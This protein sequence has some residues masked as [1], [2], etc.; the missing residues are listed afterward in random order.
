MVGFLWRALRSA[1][2]CRARKLPGPLYPVKLLSEQVRLET[3]LTPQARRASRFTFAAKRVDEITRLAEAN[4]KGSGVMNGVYHAAVAA[5]LADFNDQ[6]TGAFAE[7][8]DLQENHNA[9]G[10]LA[11]ANEIKSATDGYQAALSRGED[12]GNDDTL[13]DI[14]Q[15]VAANND[16]NARAAA[17]LQNASGTAATSSAEATHDGGS[18]S[19]RDN[20]SARAENSG[21]VQN[22]SDGTAATNAKTS[23]LLRDGSAESDA[24]SGGQ[25]DRN[26]GNVQTDGHSGT[27]ANAVPSHTTI[28]PQVSSPVADPPA[29]S[30]LTATG[31]ATP[32]FIMT[33]STTS[34]MIGPPMPSSAGSSGSSLDGR[35]T[36]SGS[37]SVPS[38]HDSGP[39]NT[40][41]SSGHATSSNLGESGTHDNGS[42][43]L[44]D[45]HPS[46]GGNG[47][48]KE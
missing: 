15:F 33:T 17:A 26:N 42:G 23:A 41:A 31:T 9:T 47:G 16:F 35:G 45:H 43:S 6:V 13:P 48:K 37:P 18:R 12:R 7:A 29:P 14:H 22:K 21:R 4:A 28:T 5:A 3:A 10:S 39:S 30:I 32:A 36:S 2:F 20:G 44:G 27:D 34:A 24:S 46:V 40:G 1:G 38:S 19:G 11:I 25:G 8:R